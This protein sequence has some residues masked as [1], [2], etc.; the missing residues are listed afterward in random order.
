MQII[1]EFEATLTLTCG[2]SFN[3]YGDK[4]SLLRYNNPDYWFSCPTSHSP[5][6]SYDPD[7]GEPRKSERNQKIADFSMR[8]LPTEHELEVS[9]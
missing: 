3:L 6:V 4:E 7:T 8:E 5:T 9:P 2:C 1:T